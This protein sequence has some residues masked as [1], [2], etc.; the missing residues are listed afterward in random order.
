MP[1]AGHSETTSEYKSTLLIHS[2]HVQM[3]PF[4][5]ECSSCCGA[6]TRVETDG[7]GNSRTV[8]CNEST[9]CCKPVW[10][11][12]GTCSSCC[13]EGRQIEVDGCGNSRMVRC[14]EDTC[15]CAPHWSNATVCSS[16]CGAG[17]YREEVRTR[18]SRLQRDPK[19]LD[20]C[21]SSKSL[22]LIAA[23]C[24]LHR[25]HILDSVWY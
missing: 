17:T 5:T 4:M 15:C 10:R 25:L 9:C 22:H 18:V 1:G 19:S 3:S 23:G 12:S 20:L 24:E 2:S 6:G 14:Q 13:G 8:T 7:C 16:C 21:S 11:K